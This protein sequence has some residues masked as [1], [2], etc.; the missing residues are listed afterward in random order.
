M[1]A[2][3]GCP[4]RFNGQGRLIM[5][6]FFAGIDVGSATTKAAVVSAEGELLGS[7]IIPTGVSA[8]KAAGQALDQAQ[9]AASLGAGAI[10]RLV[11][12]GYGR[13]LVSSADRRITEITCHAVGAFEKLGF[14]L[15]LIDIGGQ[16]SKA[17]AI[18]DSGKVENFIMN[19][20][21]AA[22][23]GRF[24][25]V[26]ARV[27]DTDLENMSA[28][29]LRAP[30]RASINSMCTVFAETEV[31]SLIARETDRKEI[32]SGLCW[33]VAERVGAMAKK[34]GV[35]GPVF[36]SGGVA[37]NRAVLSG[38]SAQLGK[39]VHMIEAPQLN[40]AFGAALLA[41]RDTQ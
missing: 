15:T 24:L 20:R 16:D 32:A 40:G 7:A 37:Y 41:A 22:G 26:M 34:V 12:T 18:S 28:M 36:V 25:E 1:R 19:D 33:S 11:A 31:V 17:I 3:Q 21:C 2:G 35:N 30:R 38:L 8:S 39:A 6:P 5:N 9:K 23:T 29:A 4:A 13:K 10:K 14:A 27:L